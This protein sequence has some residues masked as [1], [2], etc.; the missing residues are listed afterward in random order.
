MVWT[1]RIRGLTGQCDVETDFDGAAKLLEEVGE[2][3]F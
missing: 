2:G 1:V 3:A